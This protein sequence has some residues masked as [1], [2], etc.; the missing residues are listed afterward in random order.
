M[1][2]SFHVGEGS[3]GEAG[4]LTERLNDLWRH[5]RLHECNDHLHA[6]APPSLGE[7]T[8]DSCSSVRAGCRARSACR[9][10][11]IKRSEEHTSELQ[12]LLRISY[13]VFCLKKKK[14]H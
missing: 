6:D 14:P 1:S 4:H 3:A 5:E 12:S 11:K 8:G 2:E 13:A 7:G 10:S 9:R